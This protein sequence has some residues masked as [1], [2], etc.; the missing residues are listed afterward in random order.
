M[1]IYH[2][3]MKKLELNQLKNYLG[4]GLDVLLGSTK[5]DL[6][7]VSLDSPYVFVTAWKGSREKQM[8][9]I[10]S[11]K[12][13][14]HRLSDLDKMIPELGFVPIVEI[15]KR[16][17]FSKS[18]FSSLIQN[19]GKFTSFITINMLF[20]WHFWIFDQSYFEEGL[21]IDKLTVT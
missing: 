2:S 6:T 8:C 1:T 19:Q 4:T 14:M 5:R 9:G 21:I 10:E 12:P 15:K 3:D 18:D 20:E 16:T 13:I 11:I 7:A 17:K